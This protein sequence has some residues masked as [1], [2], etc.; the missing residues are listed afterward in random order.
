[1]AERDRVWQAVR[2]QLLYRVHVLQESAANTVNLWTAAEIRAA[3][4]PYVQLIRDGLEQEVDANVYVRPLHI[5]FDYRQLPRTESVEY[6]SGTRTL[7][8]PEYENLE[9]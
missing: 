1:Q 8:N 7:S 5:S 2:S 4:S 3:N 9:R 6:Q